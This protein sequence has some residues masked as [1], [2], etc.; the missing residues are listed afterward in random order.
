MAQPK[1]KLN[2]SVFVPMVLLLI[3]VAFAVASIAAPQIVMGDV[4][5]YLIRTLAATG[6]KTINEQYPC[7][8]FRESSNASAAMAIL[9]CIFVGFAASM[10]FLALLAKY[11]G[12]QM[13]VIPL[14]VIALL[15]SI[16][17]WCVELHVFLDDFCGAQPLKKQG[18]TLAG[19]F[20]CLVI[21]TGLSLV[22]LIAS[23]LLGGKKIMI[24]VEDDEEEEKA[25]PQKSEAA[26]P[27]QQETQQQ[28]QESAPKAAATEEAA[29][30]EEP[31][32]EEAEP[33]KT[34]S[35]NEPVSN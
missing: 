4:K 27:V 2:I 17:S 1:K 14:T 31:K 19:G 6:V 29:F 21:T 30:E 28:E 13:L 12:E 25:A 9:A 11:T 32:K 3:T 22:S 34:P 20:A 8:D 33:A 16:V 5:V 35:S 7:N 15:F 10:N 24:P 23:I 26:T 18:F